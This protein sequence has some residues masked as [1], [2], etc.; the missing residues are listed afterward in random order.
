MKRLE[1]VCVGMSVL[2]RQNSGLV[3]KKWICLSDGVWMKKNLCNMNGNARMFHSSAFF[4][5]CESAFTHI[6]TKGSA[7]MVDVVDKPVTERTAVAEAVVDLG[8]KA[9]IAVKKN[10]V[11]KG[12]VLSVAQIA[13]IQGAKLTSHLI[14]LC[15]NINLTHVD[16]TMELLDDT[17]SVRIT[18]SAQAIAKTGVEMEALTAVTVAA[19]TVYD[20]CKSVSKGIVI[21]DVKLLKKMGGQSGDY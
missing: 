5:I 17:H 16:V 19:L 14:P 20:M 6:N 18:G 3:C 13:G 4:G 7:Q 11:K 12:S 2:R 10:Q 8:E 21:R 15:H 1:D 9:F